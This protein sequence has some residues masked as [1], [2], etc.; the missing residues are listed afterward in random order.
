MTEN[1]PEKE[2]PLNQWVVYTGLA[3]QMGV[4]IGIGVFGGIWLDE[5]FPNKSSGFTIACSLLGVFI[6]LYQ[7]YSSL[8]DK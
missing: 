1:K 8:K 7:V 2:K 5:Q 3:F 4:V 6:A